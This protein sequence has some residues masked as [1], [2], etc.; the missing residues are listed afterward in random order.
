MVFAKKH[1]SFNQFILTLAVCFAVL[2]LNIVHAETGETRYVSDYLLINL[3]TAPKPPF[4][5]VTR[6]ETGDALMV[7]DENDDYFKVKTTQN[8]IGWVAKRYTTAKTP[9]DIIIQ[10]LEKKVAR[11][12]NS[13]NEG[14]VKLNNENSLLQSELSKAETKITLLSTQIQALEEHNQ[15][16][17]SIDPVKFKA[18]KKIATD[19]QNQSALQQEAIITLE[20]NNKRLQNKWRFYWFLAGALV[21]LIGIII[22]KFPS[23]KQKNSLS[24]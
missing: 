1:F 14:F 13:D 9:K 21:L 22:G 23:K 18:M 24:F 12:E 11:L 5:T 7:L 17:K 3:K 10:E 16:L 2:P 6:I 15:T 19:M 8:K 20:E 4:S